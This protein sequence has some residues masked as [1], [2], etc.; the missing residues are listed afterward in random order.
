MKIKQWLVSSC[1]VAMM[2]VPG[3]SFGQPTGYQ[4]LWKDTS[5]NPIHNFYIQH[6]LQGNSTVVIYT[7]DA[8][9]FY[10]FLGSM[11]GNTFEALSLDPSQDRGLH[12]S[13]AA[14]TAGTATITN[15]TVT[16]NTDTVID[17]T[18]TFQAQLTDRSG[19][20]KDGSNVLS[21]YVQDYTVGS[22]VIV[23]T[24]DA[25]D[26][27]AFLTTMSGNTFTATDLGDGTE[28]MTTVFSNASSGNVGVTPSMA[29]TVLSP[30]ANNFKDAF[31]WSF[32]DGA[33]STLQNPQH[34]YNN[35]GTYDVSLSVSNISGSTL[36]TQNGYVSVAATGTPPLAQFSGMPTS[37]P[38]PLAVGFIDTSLGSPTSWMWNFGDAGD[39]SVV[40]SALQN[41]SHNFTNPGVYTVTL[42]ASNAFGSNGTT[43][44]NYISV[45][46]ADVMPTADFIA[47]TVTTGPSPLF[48]TFQDQSTGSPTSWQWNFGDAGDPNLVQSLLQNPVHNYTAVGIYT[49]KL[50]V[51]NT[52]GSNTKTRVNYVTVT[53]GSATVNM[54]YGGF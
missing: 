29:P 3:V 45:S 20:W 2:L 51:S 4:G 1:L 35:P 39:P 28:Q 17:I 41:P 26:F 54:G 53:S 46:A 36:L 8:I 10:A 40:Q 24:F 43:R 22:T 14:P 30:L 12:L 25:V 48:V 21:M 42:I 16:P 23:Y 13:F 11:S 15:R 19:I 44:V 9:N 38:A 7:R 34:T 27:K 47:T 50:Q 5:G 49:V 31:G 33:A 32:G 52:A 18:K 6:Y 37:G